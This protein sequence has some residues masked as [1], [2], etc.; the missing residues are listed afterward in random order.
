MT[1]KGNFAHLI[2]AE[3]ATKVGLDGVSIVDSSLSP[4]VQLK[5]LRLD[6]GRMVLSQRVFDINTFTMD[7]LTAQYELFADSSNTLTRLLG[8][9]NAPDSTEVPDSADMPNAADTLPTCCLR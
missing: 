9:T 8:Q 2:E 3:I 1:A 5:Q 6:V 4:I 7:G